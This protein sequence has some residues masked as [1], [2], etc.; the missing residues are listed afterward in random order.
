[1]SGPPAAELRARI[2]ALL[3]LAPL[4]LRTLA[5]E[6]ELDVS[7]VRDELRRMLDARL[8]RTSGRGWTLRP[9]PALT[10]TRSPNDA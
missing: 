2:V 8:V 5:D 10:S 6:L 1:M 4:P 9:N 7:T 3:E